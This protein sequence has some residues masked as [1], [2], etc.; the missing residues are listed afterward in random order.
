[1]KICI[2]EGCVRTHHGHGYCD[3]HRYRFE[4]YGDPNGRYQPTGWLDRNGYRKIQVNGITIPEHRYII[5]QHLGRKLLKTEN[6][7]H[8]NGVKDDNRISNLEL[9]VSV[10]PCGKRP[11]DLVIYAREIINKYSVIDNDAPQWYM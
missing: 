6:I 8:K 3:Y 1:M 5:E 9:W 11:E 7:H 4:R 2:I 10:Q